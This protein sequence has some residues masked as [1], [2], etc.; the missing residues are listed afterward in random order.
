MRKCAPFSG[1]DD[2]KHPLEQRSEKTGVRPALRRVSS[3]RA[4]GTPES[5]RAPVAYGSAAASCHGRQIEL[6]IAARD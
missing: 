6:Q 3:Q 4:T 1:D 2:W 5:S